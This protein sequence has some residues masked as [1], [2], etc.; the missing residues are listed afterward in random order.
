[1]DTMTQEEWLEQVDNA[2]QDLIAL[3]V[4]LQK[5]YDFSLIIEDDDLDKAVDLMG[6]TADE[7]ELILRG[8][9][10]SQSVQ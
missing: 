6:E 8:Y 2:Q 10:E 4:R 5:I 1:M 3:C 9:A 7:I